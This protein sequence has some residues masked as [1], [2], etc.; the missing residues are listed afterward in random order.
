MNSH[1]TSNKSAGLTLVELLIA[2]AMTLIVLG[3]MMSAFQ[4]GSAE[5]QKGRAMIE[6]TNRLVSVE[7]LLR[8]D[9][10]R[11]TV[12]LK[13]YQQNSS[14]PKGYCEIVDGARRDYTLAS[15]PFNLVFGD[16]DDFFAGT[17]RSRGKPFR[18]RMDNQMVESQVA[19]VVWFTLPSPNDAGGRTL[20]RKVRV[21]NPLI[22]VAFANPADAA[23][24]YERNRFSVFLND[25]RPTGTVVTGG[26]L[27]S[28]AVRANRLGHLE[29]PTP[30]AARLDYLRTGENSLPAAATDEDILISL[31]ASFDIRV[32]DP[33]TII[34]V[35]RNAALLTEPVRDMVEPGD[36][37]AMNQS[38]NGVNFPMG[39]Q[40]NWSPNSST[41]PTSY[42][43]GAFVDLPVIAGYGEAVYDTGTSRYDRNTANDRGSNGVD[44]DG[45]GAIDEEDEKTS[46]IPFDAAIRGVKVTVRVFEPI[47]Q[48]VR[49]LSVVKSFISQ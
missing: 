34:R 24:F 22:T 28:L 7:S 25:P 2:M 15:D 26:S 18:G 36:M 27:E 19:E 21:V 45:D 10:S 33:D 12:E 38:V 4:Y 13:P 43:D 1:S 29:F 23:D 46:V 5:M 30:Q 32:F 9:L 11:L 47:T 37:M 40:E 3:A 48:Q 17:I 49:Q 6:M 35:R 42:V 20:F 41:D 14:L 39:G 31:V 16:N 8:E 44:D